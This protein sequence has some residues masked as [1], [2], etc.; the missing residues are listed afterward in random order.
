MT[1]ERAPEP[2]RCPSCG[3][4]NPATAQWCGQ[5]LKRF[6]PPAPPP[7]PPPVL[8]TAAAGAAGTAV[9]PLSA[10]LGA[11]APEGGPRVPEG[12]VI[13]RGLIKATDA[14]IFWTCPSC[15]SENPMTVEKCSVCGHALADAMRPPGK[16]R[17]V[18]DPGKAALVSLFMPGAGHAYLGE[19]G[20]AIARGVIALWVFGVFAFSALQGPAS[21]WIAI[22]FAVVFFLLWVTCAHDAYREA[23][24]Q[25]SQV[26][27]K[28][29]AFMW[30]TI[31]LLLLLMAAVVT[32]GLTAEPATEG[33]GQ[34]LG[35]W[36]LS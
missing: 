35:A 8:S 23:S 5:C 24:G 21:R 19:W 9:D 27:L 20:Q 12:Q 32:S 7:P 36:G 13:Q 17:P 34:V 2:I 22:T 18:R 29:R 15:Q 6:A 25:T 30:L 28:G 14:G 26:L 16:E 1:P 3:G 11:L 10:P 31:G 4:L 33:E